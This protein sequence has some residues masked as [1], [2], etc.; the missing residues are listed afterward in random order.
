[1]YGINTEKP[2][3]M[4]ID[5]NSAFAT[6]EQQAHPS[7]RGKP[8]GVT[9]RLSKECCVIA[10]SY[11]A[12]GIGIKV[13][14]RRTE[15]VAI[16]PS[17]IL[18]ETDPPK[19]NAV[20]QKLIKIMRSYSPKI[21]M[22]SIDEGI[23]DF[24]G[25][26]PILAGRTLQDIGYE[27]KQ[28]VRDE[29]GDWMKINVGIGTNRFLAKEAAGW[30]KP[31]GLDTIDHTNLLTYYKERSLTDL[32]G[33]A[34][35]YGA[36]L[37]AYGIMT[38]MDFLKAPEYMLKKQVFKSIN[39]L[40]WYMRLRGFEIDD[41]ETNLGMVGRQWVVKDPSDKDSYLL[42]CLSFLCE[43][44]GMKL[45]FREVEARGVCIWLSYQNGEYWQSKDKQKST[46]YTNQEIYRRAMGIFN[47][48]PHGIVRTMGIYCYGLEP[49]RRSQLSMFDDVAKKDWLTKSVDE[50][51]DFYGTFTVYSANSLE[52]KKI[53][54]QKI[55]FGGTEYFELLLKSA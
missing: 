20:Y 9:N 25:M 34:D 46:F 35:R 47:K 8:M 21:K 10:A 11:E 49:S 51:N 43:T 37:N 5:L 18:L 7:L 16:C 50:I 27:I 52:G 53:I 22:K 55:P 41:Y 14:M 45:R 42:P 19:Y 29:I 36:R 4:H 48:R 13:G 28:R 17:F 23:I 3:V 32:S 24:H 40:Y 31:D 44:T 15:A 39:G 54:K 12:K 2:M 33:I 6:A 30:H 38:P 1:M 26:E